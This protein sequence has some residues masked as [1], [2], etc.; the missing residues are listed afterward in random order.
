MK[1]LHKI[2]CL[3]SLMVILLGIG[4]THKVVEGHS[5]GGGGH[6]G[7]GHGGI[8]H[9]GMGHGGMGHG[10]M[11]HGGISRGGMGHG[12]IGH[13]GMGHGGISRGGYY[14][15]GSGSYSFNPF[16][17]YDYPVY[18]EEESPIYF[19]PRHQPFSML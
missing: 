4:M 19:L 16:Y 1:H 3:F 10:G 6:S 13:G 2:I 11:G 12:G 8:G 18:I 9:G 15:G 5:G 17:Y 14:G 7:G